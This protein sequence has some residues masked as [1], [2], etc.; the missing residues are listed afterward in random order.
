[1][2]PFFSC[3]AAAGESKMPHIS[4]GSFFVLILSIPLP[5]ELAKAMAIPLHFLAAGHN[6][7]IKNKFFHSS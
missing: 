6:T 2:C 4:L 3:F 7:S 1:M 5:S